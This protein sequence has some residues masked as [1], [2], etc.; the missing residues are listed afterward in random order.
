MVKL[1]FKSGRGR[2]HGL[3]FLGSQRL[4]SSMELKQKS[5]TGLKTHTQ[6]SRSL[7]MEV[8]QTSPPSKLSPKNHALN[9]VASWGKRVGDWG[10]RPGGLEMLGCAWESGWG[11]ESPRPTS[12]RLARPRGPIIETGIS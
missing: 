10:V 5:T 9:F 11:G 2:G 7:F 1:E 4:I 8:P 3:L 6:K 12:V